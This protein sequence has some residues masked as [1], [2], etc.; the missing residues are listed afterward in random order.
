[1]AVDRQHAG[2]HRECIPWY[3]GKTFDPGSVATLKDDDLAS[4]G[5]A[6]KRPRENVVAGEECGLHTGI[7][8]L[9]RLE[10]TVEQPQISRLNE[11][12]NTRNRVV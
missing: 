10:E 9:I 11:K 1:M 12:G 5:C 3:A 2:L 4:T 6:E 8:D 7:G